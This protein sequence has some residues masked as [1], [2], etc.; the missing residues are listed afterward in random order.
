LTEATSA[1]LRHYGSDNVVG[2]IMHALAA[3][4]YD[5]SRL[6]V[7]MLNLVDQ[8]HGGG[9]NA[10]KAQAEWVGVAR[11]MR[12]LD[13]GC[14]IGGSSRYLA[15]TF[16]CQLDAIDLTPEFVATAMRLNVLCGIDGKI[17]VREGSVTDLPYADGSFD[18]V[19]SQNV[20]M[21]VANKL[22]FFAETFRVLKVGGCFAFS[23]AARGP[24]GQPYYPLP[25]ADEPS[26]SFLGT[27]EDI[28]QTLREAGFTD[29]ES[30]TEA[31]S[32]GGGKGRPTGDIGPETVMG[33]TMALR[34]ANAQ[35]SGR[36]HRLIGLMVVA[37]KRGLISEKPILSRS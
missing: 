28:L 6:T 24:V 26:Y 11:H 35:C 2:R 13:A 30:R 5:V 34:L 18:I 25:W 37:R 33:P 16:G 32:P 21:N 19:W 7:E 14:G 15:A 8:M 23:H 36:E 9:L 3:A 22:R 27:P 10:T 12:V 17:T 29:I 4:G 31:G 20:T 1:I